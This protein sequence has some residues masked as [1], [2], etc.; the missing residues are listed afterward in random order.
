HSKC[1]H[2]YF[3][4][5]DDVLN[6]TSFLDA[7]RE[8]DAHSPD[9]LTC[10]AQLWHEGGDSGKLPQVRHSLPPRRVMPGRQALE[11]TFRDD[12]LSSSA[13]IFKRELLAKLAP[14]VFP[15]GRTYE[16]NAT[17]PR[18]ICLA[19]RVVYVDTP[20]FRYRIRPGSITQTHTFDRAIAQATSLREV[21][22]QVSHARY[23]E[24]VEQHANVLAYKHLV[25]AVRNAGFI[26]SISAAQFGAI[27]TEGLAT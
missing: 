14:E 21:L 7:R 15:I 17:I 12:F 22:A 5:S 4:D 3:L 27:I 23:G 1:S 25:R 24:A 11:A 20:I 2:V 26:P 16:D 6:G 13:R 19:D 18:L 8:L 10:D 9:I